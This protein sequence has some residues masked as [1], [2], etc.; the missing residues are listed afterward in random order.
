[1]LYPLTFTPLFKERIWGGRNIERLFGK[2][3][4]PSVKIGESWEIT[5][6]PEGVSVIAN[7]PLA[8]KTLRWLMEE[9]RE[10]LLGPVH[11]KTSH[12]P[13]L[14]KI[15]DAEDT[16]SLQVHPPASKAAA[17]KGEPK[18]EMW[19]IVDAKP[20]AALYVGLKK[21][22]QREEFEAKLREGKL[23]EC[24]HKHAVKKSDSMFLPAG[25]FHAIGA[26]NVIFEIQQ[27]SDTTYRVFD[28]NRKDANGKPR[29]LH[30]EPALASIDFDDFEPPMVQPEAVGKGAIQ[31]HYLVHDP[32]FRVNVAEVRRGERFYLSGT[33][34]QIIGMVEGRLKVS[35]G[36]ESVSLKPGEF[37]LL[38]ASLERVVF[39]TETRCKY[40]QVQF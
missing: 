25:R 21:G 5:D 3:L 32:L 27:N 14:V 18:T 24:V 6:R 20:D 10:A 13:L 19:Y 33:G 39:E 36:G 23:E 35:G 2:P 17:L 11:A 8:G 26:G 34:A 31:L 29:D 7:G 38:P 37:A 40:L 16:L 4:P 12:F 22:V 1:M 30:I 9:H 15:L 28:W